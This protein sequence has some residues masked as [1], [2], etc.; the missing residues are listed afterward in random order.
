LPDHLA[1]GVAD[2]ASVAFGSPEADTRE[3]ARVLERL[4]GIALFGLV[5]ARETRRVWRDPTPRSIVRATVAS[6]LVLV[7]V[8]S[9]SLQPWY[10]ALPLALSV[11][12]GWRD[13]L[14]RVVVGYSVLG[15]PTLYLA[16]YLREA[17]PEPIWLICALVP[18]LP[19][20]QTWPNARARLA[21]APTAQQPER[22]SAR[23]AK[24]F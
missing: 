3:L 13:R 21:N 22:P 16:Y 14:T 7:L 11:L 12:L 10:F 18:L 6:S 1:L 4:A 17:M 23:Q 2:R 20:A 19:L 8:V 5:L 9:S 24:A 15:L